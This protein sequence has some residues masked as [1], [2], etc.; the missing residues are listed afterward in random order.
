M[1]MIRLN[2]SEGTTLQKTIALLFFWKEN[3]HRLSRSEFGG[4]NNSEAK[5]F[6]LED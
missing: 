3:E 6:T 5:I 1:K 4:L 2:N